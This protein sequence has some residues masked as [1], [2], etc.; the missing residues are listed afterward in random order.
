MFLTVGDYLQDVRVLLQDTIR[1]FRYDNDSLVTSLNLALLETRR[2]RPDLFLNY[3][4]ATPQFSANTADPDDTIEGSPQD[5]YTDAVTDPADQ[6]Y[7]L[8]VPMEEQ[9]RVA[10]VHGTAG[11]AFMRDQED[12]Q[13]AHATDYMRVFYKILLGS[14]TTPVL[15]KG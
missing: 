9:F 5:P 11:H 14:D 7:T 15:P 2:V 4:D 1:P 13:D 10:L 3:L 12:I 6:L 8:F